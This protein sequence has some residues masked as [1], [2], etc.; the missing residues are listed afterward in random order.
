MPRF[1]FQCGAC[2]ARFDVAR[3]AGDASPVTCPADG[4]RAT[5]R[6]IFGDGLQL[7][8]PSAGTDEVPGSRV[9]Q[10]PSMEQAPPHG[11]EHTH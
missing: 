5:L 6:A 8:A 9:M 7:R 3:G 10:G 4:E 11:H 2:G 1:E